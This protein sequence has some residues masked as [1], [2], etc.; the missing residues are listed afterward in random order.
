MYIPF[1][2]F[3]SY[4]LDYEVKERK[5]AS[6]SRNKYFSLR[7]SFNDKESNYSLAR[8]HTLSF[9]LPLLEVSENHSTNFS[10]CNDNF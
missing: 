4:K 3:I 9:M 7:Y 10:T 2:N 8:W 5:A 1:K 6:I